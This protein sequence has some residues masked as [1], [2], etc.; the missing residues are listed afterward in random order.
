MSIS[1]TSRGLPLILTCVGAQALF[2]CHLYFS[3][4]EE[5][6]RVD[7]C[8]Y[9]IHYYIFWQFLID[10]QQILKKQISG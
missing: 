7:V 6:S 9:F 3:P 4:R 1:I 5:L 2:S 10:T 8:V